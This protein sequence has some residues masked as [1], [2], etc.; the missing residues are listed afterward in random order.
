M[1]FMQI[2]CSIKSSLTVY[3][4]LMK[5]R[6]YEKHTYEK[7]NKHAQAHTKTN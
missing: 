5:K 3:V 6:T 1:K 7:A 2:I 4:T